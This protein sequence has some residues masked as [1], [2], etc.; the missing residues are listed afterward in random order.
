MRKCKSCDG[1]MESKGYQNGKKVYRCV[2]CRKTERDA[3]ELP[4]VHKNFKF[5]K[6]IAR[7]KKYIITY[8]QNA[9]PIHK[10]FWEC[11]KT[12]AEHNEAEIIVIPG[13][14]KNPTSIWNKNNA[15][16]EWWDHNLH[17]HLFAKGIGLNV[18][19]RVYGDIS[20][21]PTA[22]R[23]LSGFEVFA[24]SNSCIFGHPSV[25]LSTIATSERKYP[26]VLSTTGAVTKR[27]YTDSKAGKK[28]AGHHTFGAAVVSIVGKYFTIRQVTYN[29]SGFTDL[30]R[31]YYPDRVEKAER[32]KALVCGD[33]HVDQLCPEVAEATF[34]GPR[35]ICKTLKPEKI[36]FHDT[37]DFN[38]RNHHTI[39]DKF[40]RYLKA[41]SFKSESVRLELQ[42][43]T[44]FIDNAVPEDCKPFIIPS[45]HDD[46]FKRWL[47]D[48]DISKD[49]INAKFYH[50]MWFRILDEAEKTKKIAEPFELYYRTYGKNRAKFIKRN[51]SFKVKGWECGFH[52]DKGLNGGPSSATGY[53]KLGVKTITGHRHCLTGAHDVLTR[54]G[55]RP[56]AEV[57]AGEEILS[58][59]NGQM[60]W[61]TP[62][63]KH[64]N[65]F[66][67]T[68]LKIRQ[69]K[70]AAQT[71]TSDHRMKLSD[72]STL[73]VC[74]AILTRSPSSV[75][76]FASPSKGGSLEVA[77]DI[78]RKV[79]AVCADGS[80]SGGSLQ[81]H[82]KKQRKIDRVVEL[83]GED[84]VVR[85][86]GSRGNHSILIKKD[87]TSYNEVVNWVTPSV[88]GKILP[89][90]FLELNH[91]GRETFIDEL[92]RWDGSQSS[93]NVR[94]FY[95][96]KKEEIDIVSVLL[97]T[98]GYKNT[99][100][101][102]KDLWKGKYKPRWYISWCV[103]PT[104]CQST[105]SLG[106]LG[107]TSWGV[108][109][110]QVEN[111]PVYC[112]TV[113]DTACFWVRDHVTGR[114]SLTGN[115]PHILGPN[116][117]V[118]VSGKLD[119][120]YNN[121][122]GSWAPAHA[123]IYADGTRSLIFVIDGKWRRD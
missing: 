21:Q 11:I 62:T 109:Q 20:I 82:L 99:V 115:S 112:F 75:P 69:G 43:A 2:T 70:G 8:A 78:I 37:L 50:E 3:N 123:V 64:E 31:V 117:G 102:K 63:H 89:K 74:E 97:A 121:L 86:K 22:S 114:M 4:E 30:D 12:Y 29:G 80:F 7:A 105:N 38:V 48:A 45:N 51:D 88:E 91:S 32:P 66:T 57:Q 73:P 119:M 92:Y 116:T 47:H 53:A 98:A 77:P 14:Y 52:G 68:L 28:A 87:S 94:H 40:D 1:R 25:Q 60:V 104:T 10:D 54:N 36:L 93:G 26:R 17:E 120:G 13:R 5:R 16:D 34:Y 65:T 76:V 41:I 100:K 59:D 85:P 24:G 122:P 71:V 18:N 61:K 113:P 49:S 23:P 15:N 108:V 106:K 111:E 96:S 56:I 83:F 44:S 35:S 107:F 58:W 46:A 19:L 27:N 84:C 110:Q 9:T 90:S 118:G 55:W 81:F 67:G 103:E 33:I 42:R 79:V 95:S 72:G 101:M 39:N 6:K